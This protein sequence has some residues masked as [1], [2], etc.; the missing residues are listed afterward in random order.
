MKHS[1]NVILLTAN[2]NNFQNVKECRDGGVQ[3]LG[4]GLAAC[5]QDKAYK[6]Y[7]T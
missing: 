7:T 1:Y 5:R 2:A 4:M 3:N 6:G